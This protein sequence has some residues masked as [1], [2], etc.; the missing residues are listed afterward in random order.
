MGPWADDAELRVETA[1]DRLFTN[2][3]IN[4]TVT[5]VVPWLDTLDGVRDLCNLIW[6]EVYDEVGFNGKDVIVMFIKNPWNGNS[7][8]CSAGNK[9]IV[10]Y[11]GPTQDWKVSRHEISH[12]YGNNDASGAAHPNDIME[13]PYNFPN[14]WCSHEDWEHYDTMTFNAGK[15]D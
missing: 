4:F 3:G 5:E 12:L 10:G 13:D 11:Q 1:D 9:F 2:W 15:Y 7:A 8:G 14:S 6:P